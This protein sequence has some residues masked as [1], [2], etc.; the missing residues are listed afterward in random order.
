MVRTRGASFSRG[1]ASSS[2]GQPSSSS[3]DERR[4]PTA[5]VRRRRHEDV[6]E[7]DD[8]SEEEDED[9][10]EDG[11]EVQD[12]GFPRGPHDTSLLTHYS[13]HDRGEI[14]LK[15]HGKKLKN[16]GMYHE[17][18]EPY[19]SMSG[20]ASLVNL[21]YEYAD[22]G[23]TVS[24]A[25]RWHLETNTFHLPVGEMNVTLDDVHNLLHLPIMGQFCEVEDL[26]YDEARSHLMDLL[27][28]DRAKASAKMKKSRGP[29]VRLSWLRESGNLIRVSYLLLLR[30]LNACSRYAWGAATLAHT[31]EQLGDAS[32]S[33]VRQIAG[34]STLLQSWI[35]EHLPGMGRRQ[36]SDT[37]TDLHPRASRYI[38]SRQGWIRLGY[39]IHRHLPERVLR[40]FGFQQIIPRSPESLP[41]PEI[42]TIDQ[43]WLRYLEHAVTG[44][45]EAEDPSAC[46]DGYLA[47]FRRVSH[48]YITPANDDDRPSLAPHMRRHLPDDI[49]VPPVRRRRSPES[50][51][52][53]GMRHV[54]RMLQGMLSCQ[55]VTQNA[56]V[57][58]KTNQTLQVA[59]RSVEEYE[60]A[61]T[62]RGARHVRGRASFS[63]G[64]D[65]YMFI[66]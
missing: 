50:G 25:E 32:F 43:N 18:I 38:P 10:D 7:Q 48:P 23:L 4:R 45:V 1:E 3:H 34:Y 60:A 22:H 31:Y 33:G 61:T 41:M 26:E 24:L 39:M 11:D 49:P 52:L 30:D 36:V 56:V 35:Y 16:F 15:T 42:H 59:R 5:S 29:K 64:T 6:Q 27:G 51:L 47:W 17:A 62:S 58:E 19:I 66:L 14:Q 63:L 21:S 44:A 8:Y 57:Y 9:E 40:Q 28:V 12:D 54:I 55:H 20:L 65:S 13:Q 53:G 46:V 37:Y 2:R